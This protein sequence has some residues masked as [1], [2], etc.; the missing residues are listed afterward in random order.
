MTRFYLQ[1]MISLQ[2]I[3]EHINELSGFLHV[4]G[5]DLRGEYGKLQ[6]FALEIKLS[7]TSEEVM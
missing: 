1:A 3:M 5:F 4:R 7:E 6:F 2:K